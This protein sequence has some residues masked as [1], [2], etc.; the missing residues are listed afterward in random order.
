MS[1]HLDSPAAREDVRL[2]ISDLYLFRGELGTVF[3]ID[4]NH[5]LGPEVTGHGVR[6]GFHPEGR[7]EFKVD[8]DGDAVEDLTYRFVFGELDEDGYQDLWL[9]R[10]AGAEASDV[11]ASGTV[12]ADGR[13]GETVTGLGGVRLWAGK[14]GDP[15]WIEP[16]VLHAIGDAVAN[17][18]RADLSSWDPEGA[19]NLFAGHTVFAIVLE[20]PDSEL[21]PIA[22]P[23]A[24][25]GVWGLASLATDSGSWR[26]INRAGFP[27]IHPLFTQHDGELGDQLNTTRPSDDRAVHGKTIADMVA[28]VV[29][30]YGT[31]EDPR[32]Y[33]EVVASRLLP[34]MLPYR[35]GTAAVCGFNGINGRGLTD[36]AP[37]VMF[38]LATNSPIDIGITKNSITAK[39]RTEFPYVPAAG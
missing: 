6:A 4:L 34:N 18:A 16:D 33:G 13:T 15:F 31:A 20:V 19:K 14:A 28:A 37:N 29:E 39:P 3:V 22:G 26:P 21:L 9:H 11:H 25:V 12:I 30:A 2:D 10:L 8:G 1:H 17:G 38:S 7:Y 35:V 36:N 32:A 27:M 24:H 23:D 5:S